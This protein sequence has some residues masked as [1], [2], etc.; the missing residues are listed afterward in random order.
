M[1]SSDRD[2]TDFSLEA[3]LRDLDAVLGHLGLE[4]FVLCGRDH[5]AP[6]AVAYAEA[7]PRNVSHLVLIEAVVPGILP[8]GAVPVLRT[9][10][11][12][13]DMAQD[14]W[15]VFTL[16]LASLVAGVS[17]DEHAR[18]YAEA[19]RAGMSQEAF[20]LL[21][22]ASEQ[23]DVRSLLRA[24]N[25]P[26]FVVHN[27]SFGVG[28]PDLSRA[29]AS[30]IPDAALVTTSDPAGAIDDFLGPT[31]RA[32]A[33]SQDSTA[34][35]LFADIV[36]STAITERLGD[37]AFRDR[38]RQLDAALRTAITE[39]NGTTVEGKL[40][41]DGVLAVFLAA[42]DAI[43]A[44]LCCR[45]ESTSVGLQLHLGIHA[46][47]VI[48]E[49][50][51]VFGGAV[52]VTA[53]ICALSPPGEVIVSDTVRALARTSAGVVFEDRGEHSLKGIDDPVRVWAVR[54]RPQTSA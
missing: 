13:R 35:I 42:R 14:Q 36:D 16:T 2:A 6:T 18:S 45:D 17:N 32:T 23:I 49:A 46:G 40:L 3:R 28:S 50:G 12:M 4:R 39:C 19:F 51:N 5:A 33:Q 44:A 20:L 7:H 8:H 54:E 9:V 10:E 48:R 43:S 22:D 38:A 26:T 53:R 37:D 41:G 31:A 11:S 25:V 34:I 1:G 24:I 27:T 52:N 30:S 21:R 15:E 47:D 29:I